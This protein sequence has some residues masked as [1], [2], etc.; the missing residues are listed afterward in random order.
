MILYL[1]YLETKGIMR[2]IEGKSP[3]ETWWRISGQHWSRDILPETDNTRARQ[4]Y[5][6]QTRVGY[7]THPLRHQVPG[8]YT[9]QC[10]NKAKYRYVDK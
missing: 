5:P 3:R 10:A 8:L 6:C 9:G 2:M 4:G 7:P 1:V